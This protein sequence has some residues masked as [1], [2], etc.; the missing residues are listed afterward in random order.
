MSRYFLHLREF[1]GAVLEDLEGYD[2]ASV[3]V[4]K[5]QAM[6]SMHEL[7]GDAVKR[8][9]EPPIEA[10]VIADERGTHLAAVPVLAALPSS[11]S[12]C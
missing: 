11:S 10:I 1:S 3:A 9:A 12:A 6:L 7:V 5:E 8:G 4:A 2:F